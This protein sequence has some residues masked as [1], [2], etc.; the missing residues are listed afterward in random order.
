MT[1][2]TPPGPSLIA[3]RRRALGLSQRALA[4]AVGVGLATLKRAEASPP[5]GR[6]YPATIARLAAELGLSP[7]AIEGDRLLRTTTTPKGRKPASKATK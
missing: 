3:T 7:E 4:A 1:P 5:L 2:R 6:P